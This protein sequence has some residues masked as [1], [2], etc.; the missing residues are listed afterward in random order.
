MCW[1]WLLCLLSDL[2]SMHPAA[3]GLCILFTLQLQSPVRAAGHVASSSP[4]TTSS[5]WL[6]G[7]QHGFFRL[8]C[9]WP[10]EVL[11]PA[12]PTDHSCGACVNFDNHVLGHFT[13]LKAVKCGCSCTD[14]LCAS[15]AMHPCCSTGSLSFYFML[16]QARHSLPPAHTSRL[17]RLCYHILKAQS[18]ASSLA[19]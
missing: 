3:A 19:V 9:A 8:P 5:C 17:A 2:P 15:V 18:I 12:F 13:E 6:A 4:S 14:C 11:L 10:W 16:W 1:V 7:G